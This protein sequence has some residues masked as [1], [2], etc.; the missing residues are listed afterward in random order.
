MFRSADRAQLGATVL[1][2]IV[3]GLVQGATEFLPVSSSG[4]LVLVPDLLGWTPPSLATTVLLH[5]GTLLALLVHFRRELSALVVGVAGGGPQPGDQRRLAAY[6][7]L[8]TMPA[9]LAGLLLESLFERLFGDAS[10]V[11]GELLVT[12]VLLVVV[13]HL[14]KRS[15]RRHLDASAAVVVGMAQA[16]AIAP[17]ISRSGAT[18]GAGLVFGLSRDEAARFSFLLSIPAVVGATTVALLEIRSHTWG[19]TA[20]TFAGMAAAGVAGYIAI[21]FL[22]HLLRRASLRGFAVYLA[23]F[24]ALSALRS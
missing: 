7:L 22:L 4:H 10:W 12:A 19:V 8:G 11:R 5:V 20:G 1:R 18:I 16:I 3:L 9:A 17:G 24:V 2:D 13:E 21:G 23:A 6:L 14:S 15:P